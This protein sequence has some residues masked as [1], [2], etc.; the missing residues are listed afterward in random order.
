[1]KISLTVCL[2]AKRLPD[3]NADQHDDAHRTEECEVPR[4][5]A[6][7]ALVCPAP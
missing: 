6:G 2:S 7:I 5:E 3:M 1:M 4:I